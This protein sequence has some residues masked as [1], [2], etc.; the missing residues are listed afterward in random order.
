MTQLLSLESASSA[1]YYWP[2]PEAQPNIEAVPVVNSH[3]EWDLLEEVIVGRAENACVPEWHPV[4][5]ATMPTQHWDFFRHNGGKPFP[6]ELIAAAERELEVFCCELEAQGV[7]VRRPEPV[8]WWQAYSTPDVA[9][10]AG[11]YGAMPRDLLL[12]VGN[13]IIEAPM[14]WPSRL[15]ESRAYRPLLKYYF[16]H[17]ACWTAAPKP[18]LGSQTFNHDDAEA[19]YDLKAGRSVITEFEPLFDA[20]DFSRCGRDI[21]CQ[22]SH[23]T[24]KFGIEWL[25]RHLGNDYRVHILEVDDPNAMH[26]DASFVPLA[27]GRVLIHPTRVPK[28]PAMFADWEVLIPPAPTVPDS[29]PFYFSSHWL[30]LNLLSIDEQRV[31]VEAE[32]RPMIDFLHRHGFEP[33]P[34]HFRN[35][36]S[37][38]GAFHCATCDIRRRS[39]LGSYFG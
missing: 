35:F 2:Q 12:V 9:A 22:I 23:V 29:H 15:F 21:F 17:G 5:Q 31:F 8:D 25:R 38:G 20:A 16:E 37:L 24:N 33:I 18:Q 3:N 26:I 11:L 34:V 7:T 39:K 27:P 14:A 1:D 13:E 30:S 10:E 4:L 36:G 32:E 28:L 6:A 19:G